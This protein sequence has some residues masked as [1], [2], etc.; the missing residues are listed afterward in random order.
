MT[1]YLDLILEYLPVLLIGAV[2]GGLIVT[3]YLRDCGKLK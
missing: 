1:D 2:I 3:K